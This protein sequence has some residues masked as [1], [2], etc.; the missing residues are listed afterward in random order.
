MEPNTNDREDSALL[1]SLKALSPEQAEIQ[2]H[3]WEELLLTLRESQ[4]LVLR[5]IY[6]PPRSVAFKEIYFC[7][8]RTGQSKRTARRVIAQ[9]RGMG[10]I[11]IYHSIIGIARPIP[12]LAPNIGKLIRLWQ[13]K[14]EGLY[15]PSS[16][17][18]LEEVTKLVREK[19]LQPRPKDGEGPW[20]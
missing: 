12:H 8:Q 3:D 5:L 9:L 4:A 2:S 19:R 7:L 10:L 6:D 15:Y 17:T 16:V 13:K 18:C 20:N 14:R 11:Q 1:D